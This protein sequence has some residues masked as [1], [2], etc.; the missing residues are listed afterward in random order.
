MR[1][2]ALRE[3]NSLFFN[4]FKVFIMQTLY[5]VYLLDCSGGIM[6]ENAYCR[7]EAV[8]LW[9]VFGV[10]TLIKFLNE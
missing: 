3:K 7:Y 1:V 8:V 6:E 4:D 2:V 10:K 9:T 5:L